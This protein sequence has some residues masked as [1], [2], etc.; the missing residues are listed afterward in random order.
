[1]KAQDCY[2][3]LAVKRL[4][5]I[6][7]HHMDKYTVVDLVNAHLIST[8]HMNFLGIYVYKLRFTGV[9]LFF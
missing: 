7:G 6:Q 3:D 2:F 9:S 1:M 8:Q 5:S 4:R